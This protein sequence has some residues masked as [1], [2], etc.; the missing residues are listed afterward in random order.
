MADVVRTQGVS[1][2][3][4]V[5]KDT[6]TAARP[7]WDG[8]RAGVADR[9]REVIRRVSAPVESG[10]HTDV[11]DASE[12]AATVRPLYGGRRQRESGDCPPAVRGR[13]THRSRRPRE[14]IAVAARAPDGADSGRGAEPRRRASGGKE[15]G[16]VLRAADDDRL[17]ALRNRREGGG[18]CSQSTR[19]PPTSAHVEGR[20]RGDSSRVK[21]HRCRS[22]QRTHRECRPEQRTDRRDAKKSARLGKR[23]EPSRQRGSSRTRRVSPALVGSGSTSEPPNPGWAGGKENIEGARGRLLDIIERRGEGFQNRI[24]LLGRS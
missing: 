12:R 24:S 19:R 9:A 2:G 15:G 11:A 10:A 5:R 3:L 8:V 13:R 18:A 1:Q 14:K 23:A 20:E 22:G 7:R 16:G 4:R 17:E 21:S 6:A